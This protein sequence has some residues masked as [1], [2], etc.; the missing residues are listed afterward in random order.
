MHMNTATARQLAAK[1]AELIEFASIFQA[2]YGKQY[3][4][5]PGSP[6]EAWD[7]YN[8]IFD[9]QVAIAQLMDAAA[10]ENPARRSTPWWK[11]QETIDTGVVA[12]IAA[13]VSHLI[14][15]CACFEAEPRA[16]SSPA[17]GTSQSVIAGMLHP[18][19]VL[20]AQGD[21]GYARCAS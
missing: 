16:E 3:R 21:P 5:K 13:E 2:R 15:C 20:V 18:S 6:A 19:T 4:M 9:Q 7:L 17:V 11:W 14:A 8:T 1:V 12:M 10:L